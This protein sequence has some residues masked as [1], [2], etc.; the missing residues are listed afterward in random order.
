[1]PSNTHQRLCSG[2]NVFLA[3]PQTNEPKALSAEKQTIKDTPFYSE[4]SSHTLISIVPPDKS[5]SFIHML[6]TWPTPSM[7]YH[8]LVQDKL[9][10]MDKTPTSGIALRNKVVKEFKEIAH[11]THP[12]INKVLFSLNCY[13]SITE[14]VWFG[15]PGSNNKVI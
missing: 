15:F 10:L 11:I 3:T 1:M 8:I 9:E 4:A 12:L 6:F 13:N 7:F 5:D 2:N 14:I